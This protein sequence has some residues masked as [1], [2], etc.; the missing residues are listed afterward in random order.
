MG[1]I[2][3]H[4][5]LM[6]CCMPGYTN[7][8]SERYSTVS[9]MVFNSIQAPVCRWSFIIDL[10]IFSPNKTN[11][12]TVCWTT[13]AN[14]HWTTWQSLKS[15]LCEKEKQITEQCL[16]PSA[17][18]QLSQQ[19]LSEVRF[20]FTALG[21][22]IATHPFNTIAFLQ[23]NPGA[24]RCTAQTNFWAACQWAHRHEAILF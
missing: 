23:I 22:P 5:C 24:A 18:I 16:L 8:P 6:L 14:I 12:S 7:D 4:V 2:Y 1:E 21:K 19:V 17:N 13:K 20:H 15:S 9:Y 10:N 11:F 3:L